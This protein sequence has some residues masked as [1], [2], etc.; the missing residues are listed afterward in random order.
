MHW[1]SCC[2]VHVKRQRHY[3]VVCYLDGSHEVCMQR[4]ITHDGACAAMIS[5][6]ISQTDIVTAAATPLL[7]TWSQ[8]YS[9]WARCK[10]RP[11]QDLP[12][13]SWY[14]APVYQ[15]ST[16][17]NT[18]PLMRITSQSLSGSHHVTYVMA[19]RYRVWSAKTS[20]W[21][22]IAGLPAVQVSPQ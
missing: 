21:L 3:S 10:L 2:T 6:G 11:Q 14:H 7:S 22:H 17:C 13:P 18:M 8:P 15:D 19:S 20:T 4:S 1:C 9:R 5:K 12:L 16:Q